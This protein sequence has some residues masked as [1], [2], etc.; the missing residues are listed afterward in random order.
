MEKRE[1]RIGG[2]I[3]PI[4]TPF[5]EDESINFDELRHQVNRL[6]EAGVGGI[7]P[8]G[9]NGEAY[10]L[11]DDEKIEILKVVVDETKGRVPVYAGTGCI[12][13][14]DTI[15]LSKRAKE[16]GAD[17]LSIITPYFAAISQ[18]ELFEHYKA[19]A[20]AVDLPI[21]LYNIPMRTA[22]NI[23]PET[24][25]RIA[26]AC[27]NVVGAKDSSGK[28][29]VLSAY[30][31]IGERLGLSILSGNDSLILRALQAG[32]L[33]GIAGCSNVYPNNM[34]AICKNFAK[35]DIEAAQKAQ[36]AIANFRSCF[37]YGNPNTI[38][39]TATALLGNNVGK[40]RRPFCS[41]SEE[42]MEALKKALAVDK[43]NGLN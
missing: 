43:E 15:A 17:I 25:E 10:A 18:D 8:F 27:P 12:T 38:V 14:R 40:C 7:F 34:V 11:S 28:W 1:P 2:I 24:V 23:E 42:G 5:Y 37:K 41:V 3:T 32:A 19:V 22:C 20:E 26:K 35:G 29:E 36:D 31:E 4:L 6:V 30:I 33:G 16:A 9:T 21:V 39:K 13:T